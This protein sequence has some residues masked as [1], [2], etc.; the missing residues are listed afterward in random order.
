MNATVVLATA[1]AVIVYAASP[2]ASPAGTSAQSP[3]T[4]PTA[5]PTSE[6]TSTPLPSG[7]IAG[8]IVNEGFPLATAFQLT[9]VPAGIP[10]P[11]SFPVAADATVSTDSDGNFLKPNLADG[12]YLM[13]FVP[14]EPVELD[15]ALPEELR[16]TYSNSVIAIPAMRVTVANGETVYVRIV[17][18]IPTPVVADDRGLGV[19][20]ATPTH[21]APIS[22][23][24][25]GTTATEPSQI[26]QI[27]VV[28][29][30]SLLAVACG[31]VAHRIR[32]LR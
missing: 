31:V 12:D 27:A 28:L 4:T 10:Q 17:M 21:V 3:T 6:T 19:V 14:P 25:T 18:R 29:A 20:S 11:V 2:F 24:P 15:T 26:S 13:A 1:L 30:A 5:S 8:Q 9:I 23:P 7:A 22:L 16:V 32:P